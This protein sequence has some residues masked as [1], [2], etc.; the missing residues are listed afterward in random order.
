M[1]KHMDDGL[2]GYALKMLLW[3]FMMDTRMGLE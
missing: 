3:V 2:E 1:K